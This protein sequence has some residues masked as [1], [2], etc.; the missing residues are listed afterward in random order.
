MLPRR[1]GREAQRAKCPPVVRDVAGED[2]GAFIE[3]AGANVVRIIPT[4]PEVARLELLR[5]ETQV[6]LLALADLVSPVA[7]ELCIPLGEA[8]FPWHLG[9]AEVAFSLVPAAVHRPVPRERHAI[10]DREHG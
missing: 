6:L 7:D 10:L 8:K 9:A 4:V 2:L 5:L 3:V 1:I